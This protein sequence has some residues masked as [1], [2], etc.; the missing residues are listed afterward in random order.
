MIKKNICFVQPDVYRVRY[1]F[2]SAYLPYAAGQLWAYAAEDP[3]VAQEYALKELVFLF[4]SIDAVVARLDEP[5]LAAFSCYVWNTEYNKKLA[6]A[7]KEKHPGCVIL[8]GGHNVPPDD[9]FLSEFPYIDYL[10]QGEGEISFRSLLLELRKEEPDLSA[11]PGLRYRLPGGGF[12]ANPPRALMDLWNLPS[13]YTAG[14]FDGIMRQYPEI[15][16]SISLETNRG[17]PYHCGYCSWSELDIKPRRISEERV[18]AEFEW[19]GAH[20]IEF[21]HFA[22]S[23][24]GVYERDEGFIDALVEQKKKI[25]YP[26]IGVFNSAKRNTERVYRIACK[27][28]ESRLCQTGATVSLQSLSPSVL[29]AIRRENL[30]LAYFKQLINLYNSSKI[31]TYSELILGLPGETFES[32]CSG[33]GTLLELG[34]HDGLVIYP[35]ILLPNAEMASPEMRRRYGI[36][37]QRFVLNMGGT[38]KIPP[39]VEDVTEY[40]YLVTATDAMSE[41]E[42]TRGY[43]FS[44]LLQVL[45]MFALTRWIAVYLRHAYGLRYEEFYLRMLDFALK[46]PSSILG[47]LIADVA[48]FREETK[49][50]HSDCTLNLPYEAGKNVQE[51]LYLFGGASFRLR[52]FYDGIGGLVMELIRDGALATELIRYQCESIRQPCMPL[53]TLAFAYDF[54]SYFQDALQNQNAVLEKKNVLLRFEDNDNPPDWPTYGFEVVFRSVRHCKSL[55]N[56]TNA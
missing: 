19:I 17:C 5:F 26:Y 11:V 49:K 32:F 47:K 41:E 16:W 56:I 45:H 37:A 50:A 39:A 22:D 54:P 15:Q 40:Y 24:F 48:N 29:K 55:Y 44:I 27:L 7:I 38:E 21:V 25:G 36:R 13:P 34:Q 28:W 35:C 52:E 14:V 9:T 43:L 1:R 30:D 10:I 31:P 4:A 18:L 42:M 8:F 20:K 46:N 12:A 33:V 6:Q 23:N 2:K 53:K 3:V 51:I